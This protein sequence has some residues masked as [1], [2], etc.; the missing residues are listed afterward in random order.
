MCMYGVYM[1]VHEINYVYGVYMCVH[2]IN[3]IK[4]TILAHIHMHPFLP[5]RIWLF[6]SLL[7]FY[8]K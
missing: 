7:R 2:E 6:N 8:L 5:L 4:Q 1:Y 3:Y